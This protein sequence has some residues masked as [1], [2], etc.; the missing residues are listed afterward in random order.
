MSGYGGVAYDPPYTILFFSVVAIF[1]VVPSFMAEQ[2]SMVESLREMNPV[3]V[4]VA[5]LSLVLVIRW[6]SWAGNK[7][8]AGVVPVWNP[9][10]HPGAGAGGSPVGVAILLLTVLILIWFQPSGEGDKAATR[11]DLEELKMAMI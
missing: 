5:P 2:S 1:L 9:H 7:S 8:E 3:M 4:M 10:P 11:C 6:L